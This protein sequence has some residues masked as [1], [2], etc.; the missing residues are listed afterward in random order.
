MAENRKDLSMTRLIRWT[1]VVWI[2]AL[3]LTGCESVATGVEDLDLV[4]AGSRVCLLYT[5][6]AADE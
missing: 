4:I 3:P 6:D 2:F 1:A 5:S